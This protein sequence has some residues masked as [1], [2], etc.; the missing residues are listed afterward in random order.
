MKLKH[1]TLIVSAIV[2]LGFTGC[3]ELTNPVDTGTT[4]AAIIAIDNSVEIDSDLATA[5]VVECTL[6]S[7]AFIPGDQ[8]IFENCCFGGKDMGKG[9]PHRG[10][11]KDRPM[12]GKVMRE[13]QLTEDQIVKLEGFNTA[14]R[15]CIELTMQTWRDA[16]AP[17][18]EKANA[19]RKVIMDNLKAGTITRAEA[20]TQLK[21]LN[22]AMC[23]EIDALGMKDTI[24]L[25]IDACNQTLLDSIKEMLTEEQL[26]IWLKYF[27]V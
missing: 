12:I 14:H 1:I 6:E 8:T 24:K 13:L 21:D 7:G 27:P 9:R 3:Q 20:R 4:P 19:D 17:I 23:A 18:I 2:L 22:T 25:A 10:G 26:V 11:P 15:D 5:Q 16:V